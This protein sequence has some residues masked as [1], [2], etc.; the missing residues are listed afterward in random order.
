MI[1]GKTFATKEPPIEWFVNWLTLHDARHVKNKFVR[2]D[3]G[4]DLGRCRRVLDTFKRFGYKPQVT[5]ADASHQNPFGERPHRT[6]GQRMHVMLLG[7]NLEPKFWPYAFRMIVR[8]S[9]IE[10]H[11]D[12]EASS[13]EMISVSKPNLKGRL[14]TFGCRVYVR[15]SGGRSAKLSLDYV[16]PGI[17]LGYTGTMQ[18]VLY[19]DLR[20]SIVKTATHV[21]CDEGMSDVNDPPPNVC[22]LC[23]AQG[24][25]VPAGT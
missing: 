3:P 25:P 13:I 6:I 8:I 17:F 16:C 1:W 18:S 2:F 7:A 20:S 9:N 23:Q 5:G 24:R 15:E 12:S 22:L 4:G 21:R 19:Y 11:G 14:R 10:P